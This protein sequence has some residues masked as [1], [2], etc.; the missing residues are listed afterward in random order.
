MGSGSAHGHVKAEGG[1]VDVARSRAGVPA[2]SG[3]G[4]M[5]AG[6]SWGGALVQEQGRGR[7]R[8]VGRLEGWGPAAEREKNGEGDRW[9]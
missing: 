5:E 3:T 1:P 6:G 2:D 7:R 8:Q 9:A 4:V